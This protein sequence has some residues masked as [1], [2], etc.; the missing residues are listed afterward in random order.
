VEEYSRQ[1]TMQ[2]VRIFK[3]LR[4]EHWGARDFTLVDNSGNYVTLAQQIE[5][6]R[7]EQMLQNLQRRMPG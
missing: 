2:G 6:L 3:P 4:D 5:E 7:P 1:W